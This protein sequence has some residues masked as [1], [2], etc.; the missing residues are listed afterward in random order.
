MTSVVNWF[1]RPRAWVEI[2]VLFNLGG[3]APDIFLAHSVNRF[4]SAAEY[5]PL[6]FSIA[7]P[8][9]LLPAL[10]ALAKNWLGLWRWLGF[11]VGATSVCIGVTGMVL[12]LQSQFFTERTLASLVY[13]APF[14]APLAYTGLGS[15]LLMN[16]MV[17]DDEVEW[18]Q[19]VIFFALGGFVGNFIF[20]V[21]DHAQNGFFHRTEWIPVISAAL[22]VGFLTAP[23]A[24]KVERPFLWLCGGV[25][26]LEIAVGITGATLHALADWHHAGDTLLNRVIY[27]AP[28]FAPTLFADLAVLAGIGLWTLACCSRRQEA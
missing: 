13:A 4:H 2:F 20:S 16:R 26:L 9:L 1:R 11:I 19:W 28:I 8:V 18:S 7:A 23:L 22:A 21:T 6:V 14:A 12:H 24:V 17:P 27:G 5:T 3:L 25:M 15:L 10:L